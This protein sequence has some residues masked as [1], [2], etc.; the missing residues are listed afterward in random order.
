MVSGRGIEA[1]VLEVLRFGS[2]LLRRVARMRLTL[3]AMTM[4]RGL[5]VGYA[6]RVTHPTDMVMGY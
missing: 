3:L 5:S 2:G 4:W 1:A 6:V